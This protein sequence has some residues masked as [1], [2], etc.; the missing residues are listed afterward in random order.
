MTSDKKKRRRRGSEKGEFFG[1]LV[2]L[3]VGFFVG[4]LVG[5]LV[6]LSVGFLVGLL[7]G[8]FDGDFV[9]DIVGSSVGLM[10]GLFIGEAYPKYDCFSG[11]VYALPNSTTNTALTANNRQQFALHVYAAIETD[12][13]SPE[14]FV[15]FSPTTANLNAITSSNPYANSEIISSEKEF[16]SIQIFFMLLSVFV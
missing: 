3:S 5:L 9:G 4:D 6:G 16:P 14:D 1:D 8:L 10:D 7:D 13:V 15:S 11:F 12:A 2:G